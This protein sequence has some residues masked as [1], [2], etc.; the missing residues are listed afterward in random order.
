MIGII[1]VS[2]QFYGEMS[3]QTCAATVK[4]TNG[5]LPK[6]WVEKKEVS[7]NVFHLF[8]DRTRLY[9][10]YWFKYSHGRLRFPFSFSLSRRSEI[11]WDS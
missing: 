9:V 10:N 4:E 11:L 5:H 7:K 3:R 2:D 1:N 8:N 6:N